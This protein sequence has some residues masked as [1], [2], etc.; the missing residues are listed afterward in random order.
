[1]KK[2]NTV[3]LKIF[4]ICFVVML[5]TMLP[6]LII[7]KG[8][9]F[10]YGDFYAQ[11]VPF[12][13][14][15]HDAIRNGQWNWDWITNLGTDLQTSYNFYILYSPFFWITLLFPNNFIPYLIAPIYAIKVGCMG[16]TSYLSFKY[17]LK[18]EK[19]SFIASLLYS[20]SG[21]QICN[22]FFNH[23]AE[24]MITF[25]LLLYSF[26]RLYKENKKGLF[27]ITVF[28][29]AI[30][31][32][33]FFFGQV[34][35]IALYFVIRFIFDKEY[36]LTFKNIV[37][38][39]CEGLIAIILSAFT[40]L[41]TIDYLKS[42][43]RTTSMISNIK[44]AFLYKDIW[45][46]YQILKGMIGIPNVT[47]TEALF[48]LTYKWAS[49][50][51]YIPII[52][53]IFLICF[54][55]KKDKQEKWLKIFLCILFIIAFIP[56]FNAAFSMFNTQYYA[57]WFYMFTFFIIIAS[58]KFLTIYNKN[59]KE[60]ISLIEKSNNYIILLS[61]GLFFISIIYQFSPEN[62]KIEEVNIV[63][64]ILFLIVA[65]V[66]YLLI[67]AIFVKQI[68][69]NNTII[70]VTTIVLIC[71]IN[72]VG[73]L[74]TAYYSSPYLT[75]LSTG[76]YSQELLINSEDTDFYRISTSDSDYNNIGLYL[77]KPSTQVFISSI[78]QNSTDFI[79]LFNKRTVRSFIDLDS[80]GILSILSTKYVV[81]SSVYKPKELN[82]YKTL[83][84]SKENGLCDIS[85]NENF[86]PF[87]F[88]YNQYILVD[89]FKELSKEDKNIVSTIALPIKKEDEEILSKYM[90]KYETQK[91]ETQKYEKN[92]EQ[93]T[94]KNN[95]NILKTQTIQNLVID[96]NGFS[97]T[98]TTDKPCLIFF[99]TPQS[100]YWKAYVN[101][102]ETETYTVFN[103]LM[104]IPVE[105]G[106]SEISCIYKNTT[107]EKG[108]QISLL[109]ILL[110]IG[111]FSTA[112]FSYDKINKNNL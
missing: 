79:E 42:F 101:G 58:I 30:T 49:I 37:N 90:T 3:F 104:A 89:D 67:R 34:I 35:F 5:F 98:I 81:N 88:Y 15:L 107:R 56:I 86:I 43:S 95:C 97:G 64:T 7:N 23:F 11:Q 94:I 38:V 54:L 76:K 18:D 72:F 25:P 105:S 66:S 45:Q 108:I 2:K 9:F 68:D 73:V 44:D 93:E 21:W 36:R 51:T 109:G 17:F 106:Y 57:R 112:Y 26:E 78:D 29:S 16:M 39:I 100:K 84:T 70:M 40:L 8:K 80:N 99:S 60:Y 87:G 111:Y 92:T 41:P 91:Y 65:F 10:L 14:H 50:S 63:Q 83:Q 82:L 52:S 62:K 75:Q 69:K 74:G 46:Y 53:I 71:T 31:N 4:G 32:Y 27:C 1:M 20:F 47:G 12:A 77:E 55:L 110:F 33:F 48:P 59:K 28:I 24:P 22:F 13:M 102:I 85:L 96:T 19:M 6:E 61:I 103:G